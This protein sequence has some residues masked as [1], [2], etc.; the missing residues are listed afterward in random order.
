MPR[1]CAMVTRIV[2][3]TY[4]S[5]A[6]SSTAAPPT[7]IATPCPNRRPVRPGGAP[8]AAGA[9]DVAVAGSVASVRS[10]CTDGHRRVELGDGHGDRR[11]CGSAR[12]WHREGGLTQ[13]LV[14]GVDPEIAGHAVGHAGQ[15]L[16]QGGG[17]ERRV[18]L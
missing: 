8:A 4:A 12:T 7:P 13:A 17:V 6:A 2:T 14:A 10:G 11:T 3:T 15:Q 18:D 16:F 5:R 9:S 1:S